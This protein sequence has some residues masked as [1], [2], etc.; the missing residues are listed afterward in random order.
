[1]QVHAASG[2]AGASG[3]RV[4]PRGALSKWWRVRYVSRVGFHEV[5]PPWP[6]EQPA[7]DGAEPTA[8]PELTRVETDLS[9]NI[10]LLMEAISQPELLVCA[11]HAVCGAM[12]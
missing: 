2:R 7:P 11:V 12:V 1:M 3:W 4:N 5:L 6:H 10:S 9:Q 8:A